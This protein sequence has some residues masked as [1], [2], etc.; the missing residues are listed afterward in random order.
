[1][2]WVPECGLKSCHMSINGI[3]YIIKCI[4]LFGRNSALF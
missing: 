3:M 1:M 2:G 4:S